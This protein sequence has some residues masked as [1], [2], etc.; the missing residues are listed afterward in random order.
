MLRSTAHLPLL[1]IVLL[2][3][4][5]RLLTAIF[6]TGSIDY[7]GA[8]YARIAENLLNGTGYVGMIQ[9]TEL[10]FPPLFP[11]LIA[12]VSL[13]TR[14]PELAGRLVSATMGSLLVLPIFYITVRLYG[15]KVAYIAAVLIACH[16]LLVGYAS[17]VFVE[18]TYMALLFSGVYWSLQC[19]NGAGR[20]FVLAGIFF[21]LAYLARPEAALYPFLTVFLLVIGTLVMNRP[22]V[23][24]ITVRCGLL[25]GAFLLL[26][27]PYVVWLSANAGEFRWEGKTAINYPVSLAD[28]DGMNTG[29]LEW[30][31]TPNLEEAGILNRSNASVIASTHFTFRDLIRIA[32]FNGGRNL[33]LILKSISSGLFLGSPLLFGLAVLGLLRKP[34][35]RD[36][37]ITQVYLIFVCLGV[38]ILA[39][40][41]IFYVDQ[42]FILSVLPIMII[43][44]SNGISQLSEWASTTVRRAGTE[45]R[46]GRKV[47]VAVGLIASATLLLAAL[48]GVRGVGDLTTFDYQSRPLKQVGRWLDTL[49]PG[50]K[51]IM[52]SSTVVAFNAG[53]SFVEFPYAAAST[54]LKYIEKKRVNF[55]V[56]READPAPAPYWT[57]WL[58]HGIPDQRARLIFSDRTVPHERLM[59]YQWDESA[60]DR[61]TGRQRNA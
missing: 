11:F 39:T 52:D 53:A 58:T 54:A 40:L 45:A 22:A 13:L 49:L 37:I 35:N 32:A 59:I 19:L 15:R 38:P 44:A 14:S 28:A 55:I 7:E 4:A 12:S 17:T 1:L 27:S 56:L 5:L 2:A 16:P 46:T 36:A 61:R 60:A 26:V 57:D 3:F 6:L 47:G 20:S 30:A 33:P 31:I 8:E 25:L 29:K 23:R 9:G 24:H 48:A 21:G 10:K 18:T 41:S 51:V 34:W 42:R 43:W 50:P